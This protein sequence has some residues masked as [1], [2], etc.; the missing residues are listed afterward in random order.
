[1]LSAEVSATSVEVS[2]TS[3]VVAEKVPA[4]VVSI[5]AVMGMFAGRDGIIRAAPT[6][7]SNTKTATVTDSHR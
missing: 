3:A 6:A 4:V 7:A 2:A 1:M 5:T